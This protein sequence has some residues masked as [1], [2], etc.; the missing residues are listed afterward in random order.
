MLR[1]VG[2]GALDLRASWEMAP[3]VARKAARLLDWTDDERRAAVEE[4]RA[5]L[6]DDLAAIGAPLPVA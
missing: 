3:R 1:R 4:L 6:A 5:G 2:P